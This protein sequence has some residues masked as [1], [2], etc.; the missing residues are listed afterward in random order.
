ML[1]D[2]RCVILCLCEVHSLSWTPCKQQGYFLVVFRQIRVCWCDSPRLKR[3]FRWW[4]HSRVVLPAGT[5]LR[6]LKND[7]TKKS[8][9]VNDGMTFCSIRYPSI[10][11][12]SWKHRLK[13]GQRQEQSRDGEEERGRKKKQRLHRQ[14]KISA[15]NIDVGIIKGPGSSHATRLPKCVWYLW[16]A[17]VNALCNQKVGQKTLEEEQDT[18]DTDATRGVK[19]S[20][21]HHPHRSLSTDVFPRFNFH[22]E[23]SEFMLT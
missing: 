9:R 12:I 6:S 8:V 1:D 17:A 5:R 23:S 22:T 16:D 4:L 13:R 11:T 10:N 3:C 19:M 18:R 21:L 15:P 20:A 7:H 2:L 14:W